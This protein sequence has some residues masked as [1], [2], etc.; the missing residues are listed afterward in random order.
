M[1]AAFPRKSEAE[2]RALVRDVFAHFGRL[3]F[4]LLKF[5][6][7][8][9]RR[10]CS[11]ASSSRAIE[12][13]HAAHRQ[14]RGALLFTG[15]FGFWEDERPRPRRRAVPDGRCSRARSTIRTCTHCS[16]QLRSSTGNHVIYRRGALRR[17]LRALSANQGVAILIDQHIQAPDA[18]HGELLRPAGV[19]HPGAGRAGAADRRARS[20]P[21]SRCRCPTAGIRCIYEH[22]V[23][24][25]TEDSPEAIRDFTQRCTDVLEMYVRR[26]PH[27]WLWMHRRW[28][29]VAVGEGPGMFPEAA[30]EN[31]NGVPHE[32]P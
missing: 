24:P 30:R 18:V 22:P 13:V 1:A 3:L 10:S 16:K 19:D 8:T 12:H 14:G 7:L 32:A 9:P 25:P 20:S 27:L 15:H 6:S 11:R 26:H 29:D 28:R 2:R 5:A 23:D 31:G 21:C 17:V 4:E